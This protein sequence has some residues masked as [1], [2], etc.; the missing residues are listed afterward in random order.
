[1]TEEIPLQEAGEQILRPTL[2]EMI[3]PFGE[4]TAAACGQSKPGGSQTRKRKA[5][6]PASAQKGRQRIFN[7]TDDKTQRKYDTKA[8]SRKHILTYTQYTTLVPA[9]FHNSHWFQKFLELQSTALAKGTWNKYN[10]ALRKYNTYIKHIGTQ[11][12]WPITDTQLTGF[13]LWTLQQ[14][15]LVPDTVK[16]YIF[17]LSHLQQLLGYEGIKL[18]NHPLAV[19]MLTGAKNKKIVKKKQQKRQPI[20][21]K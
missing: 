6:E 4:I 3:H 2:A 17:A 9:Q 16:A 7:T 11:V 1:L 8:L 20:T 18:A 15:R 13:V 10:S 21:F 14:D 19:H 12:T 5:Q